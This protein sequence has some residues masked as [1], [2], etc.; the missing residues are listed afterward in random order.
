MEA[1][2]ITLVRAVTGPYLR[3]PEC[4]FPREVVL[5]YWGFPWPLESKFPAALRFISLPVFFILGCDDFFRFSPPEGRRGGEIR[6]GGE[7][8]VCLLCSFFRLAV[9]FLV[10]G[11][12]GVASDPPYWK[13]LPGE[14][15]DYSLVVERYF[16]LV[17]SV[18]SEA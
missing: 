15:S 4:V 9:G 13:A 10:S 11:V 18:F 1:L 7:T 14:L 16:D 2:V 17:P 3:D 12:A 6:W 5:G 8:L